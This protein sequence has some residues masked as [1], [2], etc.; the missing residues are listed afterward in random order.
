[1]RK[2]VFD[3]VGLST[4]ANIFPW[5]LP[6]NAQV[7]DVIYSYIDYIKGVEDRI[8]D[9]WPLQRLRY[10]LQ[11]QMAHFVYP[12]ATH[13][14]FNHS[15]GVMHVSYKYM[16][17]LIKGSVE[18][19]SQSKYGQEIVSR[20]RELT[21]A[22]RLLGLLHDIGHGPFS[23]AFDE[24]VYK[25]REFIPYVV[26][27]HEVVGYLLY[28]YY[29]RDLIYKVLESNSK[30]LSIDPEYV[31]NILDE[32]MKPPYGMRKFTELVSKNHLKHPE[33]FYIPTPEKGL[34]NVV[35]LVVR[36]FIYTSDIMDYLKRDSYFT[37]LAIGEINEE[38]ILRNTFIVDYHGILVPAIS[39][40]AI[41]DLVRLL[42]ARK[43]MY[44]NVY[45]HHVNIA[46][47]ET[48]G[49]LLSCIKSFISNTL[50]EMF[51]KGNWE[52]YVALTDF[53][54]YGLLQNL[55]LK[56]ASELECENKEFARNALES[57]FILRKPLW[58]MIDRVT[59]KLEDARVLFSTRFG[60]DVKKKI[61]QEILSEFQD[62]FREIGLSEDDILIL[63]NKVDVFPSAGSEV[64]KNILLVSTKDM[65]VLD[66]RE[67]SLDSFASRHGLV[68]D[69][70][71]SVYLE[72]SKYKKLSENQ[73]AAA[74]EIIRNVIN[75]LARSELVEAPETS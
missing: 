16:T 65:K 46:F 4:K 19:L 18:Y 20:V 53:N 7:R 29:L 14:R 28:K 47:V 22:S 55:S 74:K 64:V 66:Y 32:G 42:E 71:V 23:H 72:R 21:L 48:I 24:F 10:L 59:L 36:D 75:E 39:D 73:V 17:Y 54:V 3:V 40:K 70:L 26:G 11:L 5:M 44:K 35:R 69:A 58:K 43:L 34:G 62:R 30:T 6:F 49:R 51:G 52:R 37:G 67:I 31:V 12:S 56:Q 45:F 25:T 33:D 1:M 63:Y 27:N 15:L 50:E 57:I 41:D 9:S 8:I 68:G 2:I 13:T 60:P 38:W 61:K